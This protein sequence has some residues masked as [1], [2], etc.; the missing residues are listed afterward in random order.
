MCLR[1][2]VRL[3]FA[4][5]YV[6]VPLTGMDTATGG[7]G[8]K[9]GACEGTTKENRGCVEG[10]APRRL[11]NLRLCIPSVRIHTVKCVGV[12]NVLCRHLPRLLHPAS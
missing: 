1:K 4:R 6:P 11:D 5:H 3:F 10:T 2:V 12:G 9:P 8:A 7:F